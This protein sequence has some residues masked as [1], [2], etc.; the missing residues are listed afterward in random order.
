MP[1]NI[2][3]PRRVRDHRAKVLSVIIVV[4]FFSIGNSVGEGTVDEKDRI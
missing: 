1:E 3:K 4:F 2:K